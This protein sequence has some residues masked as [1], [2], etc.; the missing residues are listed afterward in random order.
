MI[1]AHRGPQQGH[2]GGEITTVWTACPVDI[3]PNPQ[4][5]ALQFYGALFAIGVLV[6][7]LW[8]YVVLKTRP[9]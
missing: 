4:A 7:A 6:V 8:F 3:Y 1:P 2:Q 9:K 5:T